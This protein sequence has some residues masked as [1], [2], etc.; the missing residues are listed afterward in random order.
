MPSGSRPWIPYAFLAL[1]AFM[2]IGC[3]PNVLSARGT[4]LHPSYRYQSAEQDP[5]APRGI[6]RKLTIRRKEQAGAQH[7][8]VGAHGRPRALEYL[9]ETVEIP[10]QTQDG[11]VFTAI[12]VDV[13]GIYSVYKDQMDLRKYRYWLETSE[14]CRFVGEV[15][16]M[17]GLIDLS[18][19][20]DGRH[21]EY[22]IVKENGQTKAYP[23][24]VTVQNDFLLFKRG[25]RILLKGE[26]GCRITSKTT[27]VVFVMSGYQRERRW[28]FDFTFD[29]DKAMKSSIDRG[30]AW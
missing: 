22:T 8:I 24:V 1:C 9:D 2:A 23:Y 27:F 14:G 5:D 6:P 16:V 17:R 20:V 4:V 25:A 18:V 26:D 21:T 12:Y 19:Q 11:G 29:A 3:G 28:R 13:K 15:H 30:E 10:D 7:V